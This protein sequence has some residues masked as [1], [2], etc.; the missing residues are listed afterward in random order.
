MN[1]DK[2]R[3]RYRVFGKRS[4]LAMKKA[5]LGSTRRPRMKKHR[6]H[7]ARAAGLRQI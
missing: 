5:E 1:K 7:R 3:L 2:L 4:T 6:R